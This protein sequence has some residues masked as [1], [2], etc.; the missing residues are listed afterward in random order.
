MD[1]GF[2]LPAEGCKP[3]NQKRLLSNF[4]AVSQTIEH[5]PVA[6][7]ADQDFGVGIDYGDV[8]LSLRQTLQGARK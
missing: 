1:L 8:V 4:L 7:Y 2:P 3:I 5:V 6:D